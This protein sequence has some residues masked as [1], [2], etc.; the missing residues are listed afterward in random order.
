[1]ARLGLLFSYLHGDAKSQQLSWLAP[2]PFYQPPYPLERNNHLVVAGIKPGPPVKQATALTITPCLPGTLLNFMSLTP[3]MRNGSQTWRDGR[4][5]VRLL[6]WRHRVA[7]DGGRMLRREE[8]GEAG[9]VRR[10]KWKQRR[11]RGR[12]RVP[13]LLVVLLWWLHQ[14]V[15][16]MRGEH[17]V[18][19]MCLLVIRWSWSTSSE[20]RCFTTCHQCYEHFRGLYFQVCKN[21]PI[22]LFLKSITPPRVV[23]FNML[24]LVFTFKYQVLLQKSNDNVDV[25]NTCTCGHKWF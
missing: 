25:D 19:E 8:A 24:M 14:Q 9:R 21:R 5:E 16:R 17:H 1:M 22:C 15:A 2:C 3:W 23:K 13:V 6:L 10:R 7:E 18:P 20:D 4:Q 12:V 11:R